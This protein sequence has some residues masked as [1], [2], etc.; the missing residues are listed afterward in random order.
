MSRP[1]N[2]RVNA[3]FPGLGGYGYLT[4][5]LV[6]WLPINAYAHKIQVSGDVAGL[7]HVEPNHQPIAGEPAQVWIALTQEGGQVIPLKDCDCKL[8]IYQGTTANRKLVLSPELEAISAESYEGIPGAKVIFPELGSYTLELVGKPQ[9]TAAFTPFTL[10]YDLTV[11][12]G[13]APT[14]ATQTNSSPSTPV[15]SPVTEENPDLFA[16][17]RRNG[18]LLTAFLLII[19][20]IFSLTFIKWRKK[21]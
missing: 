20:L 18:V 3:K 14:Q 2:D 4:L 10:N 19:G 9:Q 21:K 16:T 17:F 8:N 1:L 11:F 7:W 5:G 15:A 6:L 12:P 13:N